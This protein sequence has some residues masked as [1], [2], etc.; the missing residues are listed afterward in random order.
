MNET[1]IRASEPRIRP[2]MILPKGQV[3]KR[4]IK[5][6]FD[7]GICVMC[8]FTALSYPAMIAFSNQTR[9]KPGLIGITPKRISAPLN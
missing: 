3:S 9:A 1:T 4:D 7:N 2:V 6:L 5:K 8:S